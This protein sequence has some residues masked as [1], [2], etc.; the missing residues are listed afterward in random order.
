[1]STQWLDTFNWAWR[2]RAWLT[3][4]GP[5]VGSIAA[6]GWATRHGLHNSTVAI[7]SVL[8]IATMFGLTVGYHRYLTHRSFECAR[9]LKGLLTVLGCMAAQG[10]PLFWVAIHRLHHQLS[11]ADGDPHSPVCGP[12]RL[13]RLRA[14]FH[15]HVGWML[16]P[17]ELPNYARLLPDLLRDRDVVRIGRWYLAWVI[18]GIVGPGIFV[19]ALNQSRA[20]IVEGM[21]FGGL[22][23]LFLAH[24]AVWSVNSIGH[25]YGSRPYATK[26]GSGNLAWLSVPTLGEAWHNN[27]HA[28]PYSARQGLRWWQLDL[29]YFALRVLSRLGVVWNLKLPP[30]ETSSQ[31]SEGTS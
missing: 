29:N 10:P 2:V 12:I 26:D 18:G 4:F 25:R 15:A 28:F 7:T 27:H 30:I 31:L 3:V 16:Q 5:F 22:L 23:R 11:D 19:G 1:M 17:I 24:H 6:I 20:G 14:L 21:L 8:Y 9:P 13:G